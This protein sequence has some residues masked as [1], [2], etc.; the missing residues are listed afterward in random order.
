MNNSYEYETEIET[1][2]LMVILEI[3]ISLRILC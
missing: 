1:A 2:W 3:L